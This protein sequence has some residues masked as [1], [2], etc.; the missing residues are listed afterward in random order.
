MKHTWDTE[1]Q[2][3][4]GK[5]GKHI[6]HPQDSTHP[7]HGTHQQSGT[8]ACGNRSWVMGLSPMALDADG[9]ANTTDRSTGE[10]DG[11]LIWGAQ[12]P[13]SPERGMRST[14]DSPFGI[15]GHWPC[16]SPPVCWRIRCVDSRPRSAGSPLFYHQF[17]ITSTTTSTDHLWRAA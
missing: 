1:P 10:R 11:K 5:Y 4:S 14:R 2:T 9:A 15:P 12:P 13:V 6:P 7:S 3:G 8:P 16:V 17:Y